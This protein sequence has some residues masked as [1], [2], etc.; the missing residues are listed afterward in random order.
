MRVSL[1]VRGAVAM[2]AVLGVAAG[3]TD[4]P[5]PKA[6][7]VAPT[8][9]APAPSAAAVDDSCHPRQ[10]LRPTGA[11]P[12]P[13][14]MPAGSYMAQILRNGRLKVGTSQDTLLFSSRN[15]FT[16]KIEG[17]DVDI[18][19][20]IAQAIFGDPD[21]IQFVVTPNDKRIP[22][23]QD[24]TVD[25]VAK[26]MTANCARW[27]QVDFSSIYYDAGQRVLVSTDSTATGIKDLA[28]K[29]V[30]AATASTSLDTLNRLRPKGA[31]IGLPK[32]SD[33]LVAFQ[34]NQVDAISTD[35]TILAG[36]A[37]QDPY[38]KVVGEK[39]TSE[40]Y[41]IAL[42]QAHH[43]FTRFVNGVLEAR[44]ADGS[45]AKTYEKWLGDRFGAIPQPPV[46][47]YRD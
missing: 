46:A 34:R 35:D 36:L 38:A 21:K 14:K 7:A 22:Y 30:C 26:T 2:I 11:L 31:N 8:T 25:I 3:C 43:D 27:Q 20:Q 18:A 9:A 42:P 45:W 17:F 12:Q 40:P 5:T 6:A 13:K 1:R 23:L 47:E 16:G 32:Q 44:R 24:G 19:R 15:A 41:G 10:S 39:F 29:R 37:A 4:S 33:C 28:D